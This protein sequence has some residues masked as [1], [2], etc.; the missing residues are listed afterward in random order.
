MGTGFFIL[1]LNCVVDRGK[2][3]VAEIMVQYAV[4]YYTL[5][6]LLFHRYD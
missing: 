5:R 3:L 6:V 4:A 1:S 2:N